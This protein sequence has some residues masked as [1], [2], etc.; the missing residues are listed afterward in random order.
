MVWFETNM[1]I[2][3]LFLYIFQSVLSFQKY[4][5]LEF[6]MFFI[7]EIELMSCVSHYN[8]NLQFWKICAY[9][10]I[11]CSNSYKDWFF[12]NYHRF[13]F[14]HVSFKF[15]KNNHKTE[16]FPWKIS[17]LKIWTKEILSSKK[18]SFQ[19]KFCEM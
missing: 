14:T 5:I 7:F 15:Y 12:R 6:F 19:S 17:I 8:I 4:W 13:I 9:P 18:S 3:V 11:P 2:F 1:E 10:P 16:S